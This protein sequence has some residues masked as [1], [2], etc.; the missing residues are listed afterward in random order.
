MM[1]ETLSLQQA[2]E[3]ASSCK[4]DFNPF[5]ATSFEGLL[6]DAN[7]RKY[8]HSLNKLNLKDVENVRL[9]KK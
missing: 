2:N 3:L 8:E 6:E 9:Q 7:K 5:G 4:S 1:P